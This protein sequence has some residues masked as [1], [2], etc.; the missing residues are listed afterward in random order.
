MGRHTCPDCGKSTRTPAKLEAH[1]AIHT[2]ILGG[3]DEPDA[4]AVIDTVE[5]APTSGVPASDDGTGAASLG[6][7]PV[8][9]PANAPD[10]VIDPFDLPQMPEFPTQDVPIPE[11]PIVPD[12][13]YE[14]AFSKTELSAL[15]IGFFDATA[16]LAETGPAGRLTQTEAD[17]VSGLSL[18]WVNRQMADNFGD[19]PEGAKALMAI[20]ILAVRKGRVYVV[21]VN[22]KRTKGRAVEAPQSD[23]YAPRIIPD[24]QEPQRAYVGFPSVIDA[25]SDEAAG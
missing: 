2:L 17:L 1:R 14:P 19:D 20:G 21:A 7:P 23:E 24:E 4:P 11:T 22:R 12:R 8:S 13:V 15:L 9:R 25:Q 5:N 6:P 10:P 18:N 3:A 16:E